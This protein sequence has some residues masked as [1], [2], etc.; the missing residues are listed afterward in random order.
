MQTVHVNNEQRLAWDNIAK[1][2]DKY[3]TDSEEWLANKVL[4]LADLKPGQTL[5]DVA[6]GCGGLSLPAA[7]LGAK[8]VATDW[9]PEMIRLFEARV[10]KENLDNAVGKIMDGHHLEFDDNH[11]DLVVSLFGVMLLPDQPRALREMVRVAKPG[12]KVLTVGYGTPDKIE[13]I[14][15]FIEGLQQL[16]PH[17]PGLPSEP[18]PLEFQAAD[19]EVLQA[20][21]KEAGLTQVQV[22]SVVEELEFESGH[23]LWNWILHGNPI[24]GHI[25][26][27]LEVSDMEKNSLISLI[28]DKLT[29]K[30]NTTGA[31]TLKNMINIGHGMK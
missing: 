10:Q 13:F 15:M 18:P 23:A 4:N 31:A 29:E 12:G 25:L 8:V 19:P 27:A 30:K 5:L 16:R 9:S 11:F 17:F 26:S 21:L 24:V 20:R 2:Y 22:H 7:R 3:V 14:N 28:D 6:A 1:G